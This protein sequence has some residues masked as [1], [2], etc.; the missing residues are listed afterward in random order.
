MSEVAEL[1]RTWILTDC[2]QS[3]LIFFDKMGR[4]EIFANTL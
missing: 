2:T 3:S 1:S 4:L